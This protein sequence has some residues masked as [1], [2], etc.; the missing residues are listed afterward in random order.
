MVSSWLLNFCMD[1]MMREGNARVLEKGP[2]LQSVKEVF[3]L[4]EL[5]LL[6]LVYHHKAF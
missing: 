3:A 2:S 5:H 1:G 4:V 6:N